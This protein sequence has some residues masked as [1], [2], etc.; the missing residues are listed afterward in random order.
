MA[1]SLD[2]FAA[3]P[4]GEDRGLN[5]WFFSPA[6]RSREIIEESI[7]STGAIV[8]GRRT[9][10]VGD[11][12]EGFSDTPYDAAHFVL[13]SKPP[14]RLPKGKGRTDRQSRSPPALRQSA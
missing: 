2:G 10:G 11:D 13:T 5:D 6:G 3:G 7:A 9:Y 8:M 4:N 12:A 1:M 14:T